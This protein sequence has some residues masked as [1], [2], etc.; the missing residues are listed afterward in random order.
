[1]LTAITPREAPSLM[2]GPST[3]LDHL[4][5]AILADGRALEPRDIWLEI[6]EESFTLQQVHARLR[7]L[8]QRRAVVR[9]IAAGAPRRGPGASRYSLP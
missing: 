9:D 3:T 2:L 7:V 4:I 1:M 8:R 6:S 5:I